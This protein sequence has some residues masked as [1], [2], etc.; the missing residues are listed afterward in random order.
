MENTILYKT[1]MRSFSAKA[2]LRHSTLLGLILILG[3]KAS[4]AQPAGRD[5][6]S[7]ETVKLNREVSNNNAKADERFEVEQ[8]RFLQQKAEYER[9]QRHYENQLREYESKNSQYQEKKSRYNRLINE[10]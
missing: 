2:F 7:A 1:P 10:K 6:D 4:L 3:M 5:S 9:Q 8:K